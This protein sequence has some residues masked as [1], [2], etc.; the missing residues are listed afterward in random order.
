MG[1]ESRFDMFWTRTK[2]RL[3]GIVKRW[4]FEKPSI[5]TAITRTA[6]KSMFSRSTSKLPYTLLDDSAV[7]QP[8]GAIGIAGIAGIVRHHA[9]SRAAAMQFA[10]QFH[11]SLAVG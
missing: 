8:D 4:I 11:D 7:E 1:Q 5:P 9:D 3:F 10:Q 2:S 6:K